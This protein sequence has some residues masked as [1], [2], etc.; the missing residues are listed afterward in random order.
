MQNPNLSR[1]YFFCF[2]YGSIYEG[3]GFRPI[4]EK[5]ILRNSENWNNLVE[6]LPHISGRSSGKSR[7]F[8]SCR[9][10]AIRI[11]GDISSLLSLFSWWNISSISLLNATTSCKN[12]I[13]T[14][15]SLFAR[16]GL[17]KRDLLINSPYIP[18]NN[19]TQHNTFSCLFGCYTSCYQ[20]Y[21][22]ISFTTESSSTGIYSL[23]P[24]FNISLI[25]FT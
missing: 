5:I 18:T 21:Q 8:C 2:A 12:L 24:F 4:V 6:M 20:I 17:V 25:N 15:V 3:N 22:R 19:R 10:I 16:S 7:P 9:L 11:E 14:Q 23:C 1:Q 13:K